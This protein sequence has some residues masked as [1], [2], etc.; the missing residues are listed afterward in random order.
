[1]TSDY[2]ESHVEQ[3]RSLTDDLHRS[4][5]PRW[6]N[7]RTKLQEIGVDPKD[8]AVAYIAPDGQT[9][10][11]GLLVVRDGSVFV[12]TLDFGWPEPLDPENGEIWAWEEEHLG[13]DKSVDVR[14]ERAE[15]AMSLL[16]D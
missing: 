2:L 4:N 7:L 16:S 6:R 14:I 9:L 5:R 15:I 10:E 13:T 11:E 1:M 12:F 8:A 3:A